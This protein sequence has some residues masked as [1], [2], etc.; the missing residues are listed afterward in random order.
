MSPET[1]QSLFSALIFS[2]LLYKELVKDFKSGFTQT[3]T[4]IKAVLAKKLLKYNYISQK[5]AGGGVTPKNIL[6]Q[7][8][9]ALQ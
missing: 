7:K 3:Q 2:I 6:V 1:T 5:K 8:E 4:E 9:I